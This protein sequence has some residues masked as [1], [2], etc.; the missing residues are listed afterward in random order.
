[1]KRT[2]QKNENSSKPA[3]VGS[4]PEAVKE[5]GGKGDFGIPSRDAVA[6]ARE[7]EIE[8]RPAGSA[9]GYSGARGV[10]TTGVGSAGGKPGHD[11]GGDLDT[12]LIGF[13]SNGGLAAKPASEPVGGPDDAGNPSDT[14]TSGK[15]AKGRTAIRHGTH[16]T[17]PGSK[18]D[19]V[20]HSGA[21]ASTVNPNAAGNV[22]PMRGEE[23]G[24]E[25]EI[26][27]DEATG[28][29]DQGAET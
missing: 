7:G 22:T 5:V 27:R 12:D 26:S 1:M 11:S 15:P 14:F 19:F 20:D 13:G 23:P 4:D 29:V 18:G 28:D 10:R 2:Q 17:A 3:K 9:P 21:D 24:A 16:G 6:H 25:G 8:G